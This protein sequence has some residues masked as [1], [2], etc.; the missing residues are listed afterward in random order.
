MR[1]YYKHILFFILLLLVGCATVPSLRVSQPWIRSLESNQ[2]IVPTKTIKIEV[3]GSTSPLLGSERL[4][5]ERLRSSLSNLIKR[6]GFTIDNGTYTYLVKL[7][8]RTE[9][10]DKMRFSSTVSSTHSQ[11]YAIST[12]TGADATSG[13]GVNIARAIGV[14][15]SRSSTVSNQTAN[16]TLSYTHTISIELSNKESTI[17]WKGE[18]TWDSEELNLINGIIP[19]FQLILSDLPSDKSVRP[20]IPEV[21]DTHVKN[22]YRLECNGVWFT[23]PALPYRILFADNNNGFNQFL[24]PTGILNQNG[25][26]A[27][28]DLIQTAEYALPDGDEND[29]KDPLNISLWEKVTLGG[30]YYLGPQKTPVNI[31]ITLMGES[32]GYYIS[33]CKIAN[34]KEFSEFNKKLTKWCEMLSDYYNVYKK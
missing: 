34:A 21:K 6:R 25:L 16:Q 28:V 15:A 30:Q 27:Y 14:L 18:S 29:W 32:D 1:Q 13:L 11:A 17:L 4:T 20:E 24:I 3:D 10:I 12:N 7:S 9:R 22:Y 23:C 31:L 5:S 33:E 2:V 8:Y 26:A 19:A